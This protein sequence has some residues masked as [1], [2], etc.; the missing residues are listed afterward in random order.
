MLVAG[1]I[2]AA[3]VAIDAPSGHAGSA[4]ASISVSPAQGFQGD[5]FTITYRYSGKVEAPNIP[6]MYLCMEYE[7]QFFWDVDGLIGSA[8][9]V[10]DGEWCVVTLV[11]KVPHFRDLTFSTSTH[12]VTQGRFPPIATYTVIPRPTAPPTPAAKPKSTQRPSAPTT[13][14]RTPPVASGATIPAAESAVPSPA[15]TMS[16]SAAAVPVTLADA[17]RTS[18]GDATLSTGWLV[19]LG[20]VVFLGTAGVLGGIGWGAVRLA[21]AAKA[22]PSPLLGVH[23]SP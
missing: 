12:T 11:A 13:A 5:Q 17:T 22:P 8:L 6:V 7:R 15:A 3:C 21:S 9:P 4:D 16:A 19:A 10:R 1:L 20:A 18:D 23:D 14:A 2:I